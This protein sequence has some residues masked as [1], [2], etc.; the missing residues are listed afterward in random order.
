PR[1]TTPGTGR[2]DI[3]SS[4]RRLRRCPRRVLPVGERAKASYGLPLGRWTETR[5]APSERHTEVSLRGYE[6]KLGTGDAGPGHR[7]ALTRGSPGPASSFGPPIVGVLPPGKAGVS[8]PARPF[9]IPLMADFSRRARCGQ[10]RPL[11]ALGRF[12]ARAGADR[13]K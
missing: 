10:G 9:F 12:S 7:G 13:A 8:G 11:A 5:G 4:G 6:K 3:P 1:R 2:T